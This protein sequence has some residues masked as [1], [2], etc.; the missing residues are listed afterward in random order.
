MPMRC[1]WPPENSCGQRQGARDA[2]ALPLAAG[3]LVRV[4]LH[5]RARQADAVEQPAHVGVQVGAGVG[6]ELA[7]PLGDQ[8]VHQ[9][10]RVERRPRILK[11]HLQPL[12]GLLELGPRHGEQIRGCRAPVGRIT[13]A[14]LAGVQQAPLAPAGGR[15]LRGLLPHR[16]G[17]GVEGGHGA[18]QFGVG[19]QVDAPALRLVQAQHG[20]A[21][22]GLAAAGLAHQAKRL[23]GPHLQ[24]YAVH[25]AHHQPAHLECPALHREIRAQPAHVQHRARRQRPAAPGLPHPFLGALGRR[26]GLP[27]RG[28]A[29]RHVPLSGRVGRS[30]PLP[31]PAPRTAPAAVSTARARVPARRPLPTATPARTTPRPAAVSTALPRRSIPAT[32]PTRS[33][34]SPAAVSRACSFTRSARLAAAASASGSAL[35][36]AVVSPA[37]A[38]AAA[39]AVPHFAGIAV[40]R[41]PPCGLVASHRATGAAHHTCPPTVPRTECGP[42]SSMVSTRAALLCR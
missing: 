25:G 9:H 19:L 22:R 21:E 12:T 41:V 27:G 29:A 1:R 24:R 28:P 10:A 36:P 15:R 16:V 2:D 30:R 18:H 39:A 23:A 13:Q 6:A 17:L 3:E 8:V 26:R 20:A 32:A 4:A 40:P 33:A 38:V 14:P 35:L 5:R 34:P 7:R 37:C 42:P 31:A 11:H